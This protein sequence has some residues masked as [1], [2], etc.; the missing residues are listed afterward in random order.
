MLKQKRSEMESVMSQEKKNER[1]LVTGATGTVGR[2][3]A[4]AL[5]AKGAAVRV[6]VRHPNAAK[7]WADRGAEVVT[8]DWDDEASY[9]AAF[10]GIGRAFLL[11]PFVEVFV[12]Y[13]KRAVA[14][15]KAA[16]VQHLVRM[17][18]I[19]A[20]EN[21]ETIGQDH[22]VAERA[23]KDSQIAW[24]VLQP[25]F[26]VDNVFN[27]Q[28]TTVE[29]DGAFYGAS[30]GGQIAYVSAADIGEVAATI[31]LE[32]GAHHEKT[33]VL[34][35]PEA[36]TD[37]ELAKKVGSALSRTVNF[38]DLPADQYDAALRAQG[39]PGWM[40]DHLVFFEGAKASG[41]AQNVSG[42]VERVLGRPPETVEARLATLAARR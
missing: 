33:Y 26:F 19:G 13:V 16:G 22:G 18:A 3:T 6:A 8:L 20:D 11:T 23:V 5:L 42:D 9:A 4:N 30:G 27:F 32:P 24:T 29:G 35:G 7:A 15:A 40:A 38:V 12:P 28:G 2:E 39:T 41:W 1:I 37:A 34:T 10:E 25:T 17:S 31:L 14:A 21:A 36:I